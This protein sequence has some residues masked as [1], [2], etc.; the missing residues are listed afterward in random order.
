MPKDFWNHIENVKSS[1]LALN[2]RRGRPGE[3][4]TKTDLDLA[5]EFSLGAAIEKL[6]GYPAVAAMFGLSAGT[7]SY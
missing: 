5:G 3:M 6:G 4:P 1:I 2:E 7:I